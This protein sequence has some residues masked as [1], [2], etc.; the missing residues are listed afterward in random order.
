MEDLSNIVTYKIVPIEIN[1]HTFDSLTDAIQEAL[2]TAF[3]DDVFSV[4]YDPIQLTV[5]I[6]YVAN[7]DIKLFTDEELKGL[8]LWSGES[9]NPSNLMSGNEVLGNYTTQQYTST[10]FQSGIVDLRRFHNIYLSSANLSNFN[11]LGP[12]GESNI[13]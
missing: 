7:S 11:T 8:S 9:Y 5:S 13:I 6:E 10:T 4:S 2:N 1:N 12:R 3:G